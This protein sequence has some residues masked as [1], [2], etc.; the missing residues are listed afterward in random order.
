[1]SIIPQDSS[2][3]YTPYS[4]VPLPVQFALRQYP[5][6]CIECKTPFTAT[7]S[8][9]MLAG[10]NA[11]IADCPCCKA[12]L[13]LAISDDMRGSFMVAELKATSVQWLRFEAA[14]GLRRYARPLGEPPSWLQSA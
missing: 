10:E 6:T 2:A 8:L 14:L 13:H 1:M 5:V 4:G 9:L 7:P 12:S 3:P 11:R